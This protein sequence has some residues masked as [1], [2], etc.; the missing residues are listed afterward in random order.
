MMTIG[1]NKNLSII[2][3]D[4][5]RIK[6]VKFQRRIINFH[7]RGLKLLLSIDKANEEMQ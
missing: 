5:S 4:T 7:A 6:S 2:A 3:L 1:G